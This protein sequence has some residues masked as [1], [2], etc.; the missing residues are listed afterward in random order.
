MDQNNVV[1]NS[2][3]D[4]SSK[5]FSHNRKCMVDQ[6]LVG[7]MGVVVFSLGISFDGKVQ[8]NMAREDKVVMGRVV[9]GMVVLGM[10]AEWVSANKVVVVDMV[11][12]DKG[13]F[14]A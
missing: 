8:K 14:S 10:D 1:D 11:Q 9:V 3:M 2:P 6:D 7:Y 13:S 4:L 5:V 12:V